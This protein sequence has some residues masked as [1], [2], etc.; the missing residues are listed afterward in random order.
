MTIILSVTDY[1]F[2]DANIEELNSTQNTINKAFLYHVYGIILV[3]LNYKG[4]KKVFLGHS[5]L[6]F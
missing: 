4:S 2:D 1:P 5:Y 6:I 3:N